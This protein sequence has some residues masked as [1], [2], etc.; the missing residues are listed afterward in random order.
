MYVDDTYHVMH[1][2]LRYGL[3]VHIQCNSICCG[4][5]GK[6]QKMY[7]IILDGYIE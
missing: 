3:K 7:I 6:I 2:R 1:A 5:G 4:N